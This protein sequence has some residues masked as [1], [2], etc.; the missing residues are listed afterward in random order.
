MRSYTL[1][2]SGTLRQGSRA[3]RLRRSSLT[4]RRERLC[5]ASST[6]VLV[7]SAAPATSG[8]SSWS[9]QA[10]SRRDAMARFA[11]L[12]A[13]AA[14]PKRRLALAWD[15][16]RGALDARLRGRYAMTRFF[17]DPAIRR[18]MWDG[19]LV[20]G[21]IAVLVVLTNV[22]FP[23]GPDE[24]D[25]DPEHV[26]QYLITLAVLAGLLVLIG[27]RG[28]RRAGGTTGQGLAAGVKAGATAGAVIAVLI[29]LTFLVVNNLF[30]DI[31]SRQHDKRVA[32]AASGWTSM[33]AYLT[34]TQLRGGLFLVP[35]L[36]AV[37]AVLGLLGAALYRRRA[38]SQARPDSSA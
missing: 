16:A 12:L 4:T 30:L 15:I 9:R 38:L 17:A 25:G 29:T 6:A 3:C 7:A 35:A 8:W 14:G 23:G 31:V 21:L 10:P 11:A 33:R 27:A 37:G 13:D 1:A 5:A 34:V 36:A 22:V 26:Y 20:S 24:S 32:F 2:T 28:R 18:G 19:L